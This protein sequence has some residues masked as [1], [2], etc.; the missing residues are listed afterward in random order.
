MMSDTKTVAWL[1]GRMVGLGIV[2]LGWDLTWIRGNG[3]SG[4]GCILCRE[5]GMRLIVYVY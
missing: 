3:V 4:M 1:F 5:T 2:E